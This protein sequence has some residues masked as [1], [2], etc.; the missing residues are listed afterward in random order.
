MD[1]GFPRAVCASAAKVLDAL[2]DG[3]AVEE[4]RTLTDPAGLHMTIEVERFEDGGADG[5][6]D[7]IEDGKGGCCSDADLG[8]GAC[9]R[10]YQKT[11]NPD[12]N[13]D[14]FDWLANATGTE[15]NWLWDIGE[16]FDD[17]GLDGVETDG[18]AIP[19][20]YGEGNKKFDY[21]PSTDSFFAH[22]IVKNFESLKATNP[23]ALDRIDVYIDGGIR[24]IFNSAVGSINAVGR[25]RA[26]GLDFKVYDNFYGYPT[27]IR[28]DI[29]KDGDYMG[30]IPDV[31]Y[32]PAAF[33]RH[34]MIMYGKAN[35]TA[36]EIADGNGA[37]VGTAADAI[38][39]F[40]LLSPSPHTAGRRAT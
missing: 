28:P 7:T 5:C 3:L 21:S 35:A 23:G 31:D 12:P 34:A 37:H 40:I 19:P 25:L 10:P 18:G 20:D 17:S 16:P 38:N 15:R 8:T 32:S 2:T 13:N 39:R 6:A 36:K 1:H 30:V 33:G 27:S 24:D 14:N 11:G 9:T 26:L 29:K 22:D 4:A